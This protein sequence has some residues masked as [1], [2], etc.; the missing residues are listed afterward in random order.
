MQNL[1]RHSSYSNI[2]ITDSTASNE[3]YAKRAVELDHKVLSSLEHGWQGNYYQTYELAKKY[4]LKTVIG[5]EAYWVKDR[6]EKDR[7]NHHICIW[8]KSNQGREA[9]N[10][11]L[12]EANITGYYYRP[13]IDL[14]L[15][16]SLPPEDVVVSSACYAFTGY[17]NLD[18][19][20]EL[21]H[22]YFGENFFLEMQ[23]HNTEK[24]KEWS[25]HQI[26]LAK[27]LGIKFIVGL[28]SHYIYPE[29]AKLRDYV[30][31]AKDVHYEEE[32][33]WYMDYPDD[34]TVLNRFKEQ[35]VFSEG[36]V[37]EAMDNTDIALD[38]CDY[39]NVRVF[40]KDIKLPSLYPDLTKEEK[41]KKY[42][43]LISKKFKEYMKD[44]PEKDYQKYFDGVKAEVQTYK[45]TGMCDYP[46]LDYAIVKDA[47]EHG[48]LITATGRGSA[49]SF[50]TNT[51]CGFSKIDRFTSAIKLYPERFISTTRTCRLFT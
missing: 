38:F 30:L 6:F 18:D 20:V 46:L 13:R 12:S 40:M 50:F 28:D 10:D 22:D 24:Q 32:D 25:R 48:G 27:Q 33:G 51:L 15:I 31:E 43:R 4:E 5:A 49:V 39:D 11:I 14:P 41:D 44:I 17:E 21:F 29:D 7:S 36:H 47:V 45:D 9:L 19:I 42:S 16:L 1:H 34:D 8:A 35:G 2:F 26:E 23:Y 37:K 3:E